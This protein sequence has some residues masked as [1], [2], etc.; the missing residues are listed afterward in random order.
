MAYNKYID[1]HGRLIEEHTD[2]N[3]E[4]IT[5][6]V[7][8]FV[9]EY[10]DGRNSKCKKYIDKNG[11]VT[12]ICEKPEGHKGLWIRETK[13]LG[14]FSAKAYVLKQYALLAEKHDL[15]ARE[16]RK[17]MIKANKDFEIRKQENIE[18][19]EKL[20]KEIDDEN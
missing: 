7:G 4:T 1:E 5:D 13:F 10:I 12:Q 2:E 14:E 8:V 20:A 3:N 6:Y 19:Y 9:E 11:V 17:D 18:L 15:D 16:L